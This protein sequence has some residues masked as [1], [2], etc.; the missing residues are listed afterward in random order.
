MEKTQEETKTSDEIPE[1]MKLKFTEY[2]PLDLK[3]KDGEKEIT[4]MT[5]RLAVPEGNDRKG[6]VFFFSGF[7][8]YCEH[9]AWQLKNLPQNGYE[10]I[11]MDYR[12][13]GNS[14]GMRGYLISSESLYS[15]CNLLIEKTVEKYGIDP[16]KTP[17]FLMGISMGGMLSFNLSTIHQN[18]FKAIAA[19]V[20]AF[21]AP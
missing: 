16:N 6:I 8:A 19:I 11:A 10:V 18:Y 12:G 21:R 3:V 13:F 2:N 1:Y 4:L 14:G 20:P 5:Y 15:D 17:M 7:G 9:S